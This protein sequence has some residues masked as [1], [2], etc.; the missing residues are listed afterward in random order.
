[1]MHDKKCS[2]KFVVVAEF[3]ILP[4]ASYCAFNC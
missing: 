4:N 1:M 3:V 2:A